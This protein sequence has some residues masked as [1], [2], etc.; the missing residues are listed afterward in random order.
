MINIDFKVVRE[1][2]ACSGPRRS[3]VNRWAFEVYKVYKK[4]CAVTEE[5]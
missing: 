3:S 5:K 1:M 4:I 2:L